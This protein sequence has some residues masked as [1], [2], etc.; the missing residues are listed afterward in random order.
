MVAA[1]TGS[2]PNQGF[3]W[4]MTNNDYLF[5]NSD[6]PL[7]QPAGD[8]FVQEYTGPMTSPEQTAGDPT[9]QI[10]LESG[11]GSMVPTPGRVDG[12]TP[13]S[14]N[15][16]WKDAMYD[17]GAL[18]PTFYNVAQGLAPVDYYKATMNP[19][20]QKTLDLMK[21]RRFNADPLIAESRRTFEN[22]KQGIGEF[23]G[24]DKSLALTNLQ[25]AGLRADR[26]K[27]QALTTKQNMD[28]QY[29]AEEA[30]MRRALGSEKAGMLN[31]QE[32]YRLQGDAAKRKHLAEAS[33]QFGKFAQ[34][35]ELMGN[36][37]KRDDLLANL[38]NAGYGQ[39]EAMGVI[40]SLL[41]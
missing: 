22:M 21:G 19:E 32:L 40:K 14:S 38:L 35:E 17:L 29:M 5:G 9:T 23:A 37:E 16:N 24:G 33:T 28:N 12:T 1:G 26:A 18:A 3:D 8:S 25:G 11:T 31:Q 30:N 15:P 13:P 27:Q 39:Y 4:G 41:G 34:R 10:A 20:Y 36:Q 2:L 7:S 6:D